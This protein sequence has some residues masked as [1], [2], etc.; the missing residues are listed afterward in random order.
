M[1]KRDFLSATALS[2]FALSQA[3]LA[4]GYSKINGP[5]LLIVT[6]AIGKAN[7]GG[8]DPVL[9][10]MMFKQK[11]KFDK[12]YGFDFQILT[13]LPQTHF[14]TTLEYDNKPHQLSGPL[15]LDVLHAVGVKWQGNRKILLRAIDGFAVVVTM[16]E[17]KK[18]AYI[19]ATHLDKVPMSLGGLGPLWAVFNADVIPELATKPVNERF[20]LCPWGLYQ[21]EVID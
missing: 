21:I 18:Q 14:T 2:G 9:D 11:L 3:S 8:I 15:L 19:V 7:R 5:R 1:N 17:I 16:S 20:G 12:A 4:N 6:G 13:H 10:Q